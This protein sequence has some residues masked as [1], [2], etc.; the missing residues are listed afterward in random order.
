MIRQPILL[1]EHRSRQPFPGKRDSAEPDQF[2][3]AASLDLLPARRQPLTELPNNVFTNP[4]RRADDDQWGVRV[5]NSFG[6][7]QTMFAQYM[8]QRGTIAAPGLMPYSGS[9]FPLET[10]YA[11]L[12]H[13]WTLTAALINNVRIGFVRNSVFTSNEGS[14]L[15]DVLPGLGIP[16]TLDPRG[17]T[18]VAIQGFAG[19]GRGAGNIGNIDNSYQLDEGMY[20]TRGTHS[21]QF[22][23]SIRYR[24]TWQQNANASAVGNFIQPQFTAQLAPNAQGQLVP[25]ARSGNAFADYLLGLPTTGQ[26]I[27]LPLIPYRF[28]QVNPYFQD[29]WKVTRHFTVN[30]GIAWFSIH[31]S[32]SDRLR[33]AP[34]APRTG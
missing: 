20:W 15:G 12:Q 25:Q 6:S 11:T 2:C 21:Y 9:V 31:R 4:R 29:T 18:G 8:R 10:D 17:I 26:M 34:P 16:N 1:L 23:T 7:R 3:F 28:T 14:Q 33:A 32:R 30:Y 24:R 13:T 5:D 22:G 27:G 19:F